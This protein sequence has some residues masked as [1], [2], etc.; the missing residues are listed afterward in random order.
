MVWLDGPPPSEKHM[1]L[2]PNKTVRNIP[3]DS[4]CGHLF[5][6]YRYER[7]SEDLSQL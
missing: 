4:N 6:S 7:E 1:V 2:F 5:G 3:T